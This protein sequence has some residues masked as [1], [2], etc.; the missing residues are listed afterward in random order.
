[1]HGTCSPGGH[2]HA[3]GRAGEKGGV[4]LTLTAA[5][6]CPASGMKR[7]TTP[8]TP[9]YDLGAVANWYTLSMPTCGAAAAGH[10]SA[11]QLRLNSGANAGTACTPPPPPRPRALAAST[12]AASDATQPQGGLAVLPGRIPV[13]HH[14][15]A[16]GVPIATRPSRDCPAGIRSGESLSLSPGQVLAASCAA[17]GACSMGSGRQCGAG[18]H[19]PPSLWP[20]CPASS[21]PPAPAYMRRWLSVRLD[22]CHPVQLAK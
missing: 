10:D 5:W 6:T 3:V 12:D 17:A 2:V 9:L 18:R 22:D 7:N 15:H 20:A 8:S 4:P 14:M 16:L 21:P 19:A 1:M 13:G 11:Q